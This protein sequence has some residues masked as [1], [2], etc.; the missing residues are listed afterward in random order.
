MD[1]LRILVV[2]DEA[3]VAL[4]LEQALE[5]TGHEVVAV[6]GTAAE[7]VESAL[8]L[9][10]DL[11][12]VDLHLKNGWHGIEAARTIR[13]KADAAIVFLTAASD[14]NVLRSAREIRP[15]GYLVKPV[16]ER[17][18]L[19]TVEVASHAFKVERNIRQREH[20]LD[21]ILGSIG[22][23]VIVTDADGDVVFMNPAA[24]RLTGRT[25]SISQEL[26][27][28]KVL[29]LSDADRPQGS[30]SISVPP[31]Q[32]RTRGLLFVRG[33]RGGRR[34][35]DY[36]A[37][38]RTDDRGRLVGMTVVLRD[39]TE[40]PSG[41]DG[42]PSW[43]D[44]DRGE[45]YNLFDNA[46]DAIMLFRPGDETILEVNQR[47]CQLYG[48]ERSEF[49]GK[50]LM[51]ISENVE[52]G[53]QFIDEILETGRLS[54]LMSIHYRADGSPIVVEIQASI[55]DY[56][57]E[58]AILTVN[59]DVSERFAAE[60]AMERYTNL[61]TILSNIWQ[62]VATSDSFESVATLALQRVLALLPCDHAR[63]ALFD[64]SR[65]SAR[66]VV[67]AGN[68]SL[69]LPAGSSLP[70]SSCTF[71]DDSRDDVVVL[72]CRSD[73]GKS[74]AGDPRSPDISLGETIGAKIE[75]DGLF[76]GEL[77]VTNRLVGSFDTDDIEAVREIAGILGVAMQQARLRNRLSAHKGHLQA[78]V[79]NLPEAVITVNK[80]HRITLANPVAVEYLEVLGVGDTTVALTQL[81]GH[82]IVTLLDGANSPTRP[83][84]TV[85]GPPERVFELVVTRTERISEPAEHI[86]LMREVT[87]ELAN[88]RLLQQ[89]DRLASVGQLAAGIAHDFN[90][91]LQAITGYAELIRTHE[92]IHP[93]VVEH[94]KGINL[95]ARRGAQLIRQILDFSRTSI[96]SPEVLDLQR[97]VL[98]TL[99]MLERMLPENINVITDFDGLR[100]HTLADAG[101]LQQIIINIVINARDAM[102]EGG[103]LFVS[104][105]R[106]SFVENT[107][108][109]FPQ[110]DGGEWL[111]LCFR[112]TG[113]G[114]PE[115][116]LPRIY[117]PFFT[118]KDVGEGTGLGL[119]QVYGIVKQHGGFVDVRSELERGTSVNIFL[120]PDASDIADPATRREAERGYGRLILLV[121]DEAPVLET[122][123]NTLERFDYAVIPAASG[124]AALDVYEQCADEID[125]VLSDVV[126]GDISGLDLFH[127][128]RSL[129]P[130]LPVVLMSGY[131]LRDRTQELQNEHGLAW[132]SK[133]F[134][135]EELAAVIADLLDSRP[136]R[137]PRPPV[138]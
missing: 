103:D 55:V 70:R 60:R 3:I 118:T 5:S 57:G 125:L 138:I 52:R 12:L 120:R 53:R 31:D 4:D 133:P 69:G 134:E 96:S 48:F 11:V 132:I 32:Q 102:K 126:M 16:L 63:I 136:A 34:S 101:Q 94:A 122:I 1:R 15:Q 121:E 84:L 88:R 24:E 92:N 14:P 74:A 115:E 81:G 23:G 108:T 50:S 78:L 46:H 54:D 113:C 27:L 20:R 18:L 56:E 8:E 17:Q 86:L 130:T 51:D 13:E 30:C 124:V 21:S 135:I 29:G 25:Y 100:L 98:E 42:A 49:V 41:R 89:Q 68:D 38:S 72:T 80:Q 45:Y 112:D 36:A 64:E 93:A 99:K 19:A 90:N 95:Q 114:I 82:D 137:L 2:E 76:V 116:L 66:I 10:P 119:A 26:P 127:K 128:L 77:D 44:G 9:S 33:G 61:Q 79:E 129:D 67:V 110:M 59:R 39:V 75:T 40:R 28:D 123:R 65:D 71:P 111:F 58:T 104:L 107:Q 131:P 106:T 105:S 117:D 6:V 97:L 83:E 7:A 62:K 109:P 37:T 47:G 22:D 35:L 87:R 73:V 43:H 85:A 91:M